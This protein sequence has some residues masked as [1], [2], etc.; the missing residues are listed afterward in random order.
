MWK[1]GYE[2]TAYQIAINKQ[3][4]TL[5]ISLFFEE[6]RSRCRKTVDSIIPGLSEAALGAEPGGRG[7]LQITA[8]QEAR[9]C[10][11][12]SEYGEVEGK[13]LTPCF[14]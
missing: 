1:G 4:K 13:A 7:N 14:G 9:L 11:R 8:A 6:L 3:K 2:V 5:L 10:V 12:I